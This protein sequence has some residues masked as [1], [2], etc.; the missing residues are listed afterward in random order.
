MIRFTDPNLYVK[1]TCAVQLANTQTGAIEFWSNKVQ[2]FNDTANATEDI[3]RAGLGNGIAT[4]LTSD[5]ERTITATCANFSLKAKAMK[6][7][8]TMQYSGIVPICVTVTATGAALS[9]DISNGV[10]VA[11]YGY[12]QPLCYVQEV[13]A[14]SPIGTFGTPYSI[15][16]DGS[17]SGFT[18]T[19]GVTYKVWYFVQ[20]A[21]AHEATFYSNIQPGVYHATF[22]LAVYRNES[23]NNTN[24]GTRV[25]WL[26]CIYPR[27]KLT[28]GGSIVGDQ[29]TADTTDI[30][31]RAL[32]IDNDLIGSSCVDCEMDEVAYYVYM[33]DDTSE[34]VQGVLI[35]LGGV[36]TM[37]VSSQ[38]QLQP[39][40]VM[41][42]N[43]ISR[44]PA[45]GDVTYALT[46]VTGANIGATTGLIAS[47]ATAGTGE[48]T[49]TY[50]LNG[51]SFTDVANLV[52]SAS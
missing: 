28:P 52:V 9:V 23:G 51:K 41:A 46:G 49:L 5:S 21:A 33:P 39:Y 31:G 18:A 14:A 35:A 45:G 10:P 4:V 3:I 20:Q 1:G 42:D 12:T 50:E 38:L 44:L 48:I 36:V 2:G 40:V 11:N 24:Q 15:G 32:G 29:T 22:Q 17:I 37:P 7:G 43:S 47:G 25:G 13:G 6:G 16:T 27:Y 26:Y 19:S 34:G 30:G 8:A